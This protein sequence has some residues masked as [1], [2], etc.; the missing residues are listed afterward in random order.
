MY[1][2]FLRFL[3]F[4]SVT[5]SYGSYRTKSDCHDIIMKIKYHDCVSSR[6]PSSR[7]DISISLFFQIFLLNNMGCKHII[8]L[9]YMH[10]E[11]GWS[12][13]ILMS[14]VK[15]TTFTISG[16]RDV[17]NTRLIWKIVVD[18]YLFYKWMMINNKK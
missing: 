15:I 16:S 9:Y 3:E 4:V 1:T 13:H 5:L 18:Q 11:V 14:C 7:T 17:K 10:Y 12:R 6:R 2:R 8:A